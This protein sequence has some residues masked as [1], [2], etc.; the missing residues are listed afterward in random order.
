MKITNDIYDS[1]SPISVDSSL[2]LRLRERL[3]NRPDTE[4]E[5]TPNRLV[6]AGS[7]IL[8]LLIATWLGSDQARTMLNA[9]YKA[10]FVYF[11]F[12]V[13]IFVHIVCSPRASTGR[14]LLAMVA[15][16]SMISIAAAAGGIATGFFYPFYLWTIFGNGFRF[17]IPFL[18]AA[19]L[20]GN[21]AF[22]A[23]LTANEVWNEHLGLAIA[24][25]LCL[26][27]LPLYASVLIKKLSEAKEQAEQANRAKSAFLASIS[28]ELRTP[29]NAII[30]LGDLLRGQICH[31]EQ[32]MMVQTIC[33]SGRSLLN[34]INTILDFSRLEAGR[35]PSSFG[36]V[37]IYSEID[38][39][40]KMLAVTARTK[41]L[42]FNVHISARTPR[43]IYTDFPHIEQILVNLVA[44]A[45]KFTDAGSVIVVLD[46]IR[47]SVDNVRLR[48]E[49]GDTGIGIPPEARGRIFE[50]FTQA[51]TT[52]LDRFGG[53]GLG[54]S[55]CKQLVKL[56]GGEIGVESEPGKG[57]TFWFEVD[58]KVA[59]SAEK[60]ASTNNQL[61]LFKP[62]SELK[63]AARLIRD[64]FVEVSSLA[65]LQD[66][67]GEVVDNSLIVIADELEFSQ[68]EIVK[69]IHAQL[70]EVA[71]IAIRN[72]ASLV[73]SKP[74]FKYCTTSIICPIDVRDLQQALEIAEIRIKRVPELS[75][76][77]ITTQAKIPLSI[78]VAED[79]RTNR[80][81]ITKILERAGHRVTSVS[82]GE[83]ALDALHDSDFDAV[84]MDMNM[85]VM[86]GIEATKLYR[87]SS[88]G[89]ARVPIIALTADASLDTWQR[90]Q[91]AGMD[92]YATK[93][94]EPAHLLGVIGRVASRAQKPEARIALAKRPGPVRPIDTTKLD[95]LRT[96]G[97]SKFIAELVSQFS[98]DSSEMVSRLSS[99]VHSEDVQ[100][101]RETVHALGS[102]AGNVGAMIVF[103]SCLD[104]R[105][106]TPD[107]LAAE[108]ENW[109][110]QL[111]HEIKRS[112]SILET[113]ATEPE[114]KM[115]R[116]PSWS[117]GQRV[118][119]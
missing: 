90:C 20:F 95:D 109:L 85:P 103:E 7:V 87:F 10:F 4:H 24:L 69:N 59:A 112:V 2:F 110:R 28:H 30:G 11:C 13:G 42:E 116:A 66:I 62:N 104:V 68:N 56:L 27:M 102:S 44:N 70:G 36:N 41:S 118:S 75:D 52:I 67:A 79:N 8:Y 108:G 3:R 106:I 1:S 117:A 33:H 51:D 37:N 5:M 64:D 107:R 12:A 58:A 119:P 101:F 38:R 50:T 25:F 83:E 16:F 54:L 55:I 22:L 32:S 111:E 88:L 86:N 99:A 100:V 105:A 40:S 31:A 96:L 89:T 78:L 98:R 94:I 93:P 74:F 71:F 91:E 57:S 92:A 76:A 46:A 19:M 39:I 80:M 82:D 48:F 15:D 65:E 14:R 23:V 43:E 6:F 77:E 114:M 34:L 47:G 61:I 115:K 113:F 21:V 29:L 84:L 97:G 26:V 35:M 73:P 53:T 81:V 60:N 9:T 45:I 49:V 18:Y 72:E 17:G 63:S